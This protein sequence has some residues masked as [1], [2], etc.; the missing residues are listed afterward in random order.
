V[1]LAIAPSAAVLTAAA[2]MA[3][4]RNL[5][6]VFLSIHPWFSSGYGDSLAIFNI[7]ASSLLSANTQKI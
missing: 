3:T 7:N 4:L 1:K 5:R 2:V 6:T